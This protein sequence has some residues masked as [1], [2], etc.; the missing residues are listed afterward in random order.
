M[1]PTLIHEDMGSNPGLTQWIK[2]P[3]LPVS[4]AVGHRCS[5]DPTLLWYRPASVS[6][7]SLGTSICHRYGPKKQKNKNSN[8]KKNVLKT[9]FLQSSSLELSER[10]SPGL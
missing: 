6:T 4:C 2:D 9:M 10:L 5:S 7:P 8:N 1:N 3:A